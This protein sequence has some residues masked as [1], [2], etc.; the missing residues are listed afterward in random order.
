MFR[1]VRAL[2][3]VLLVF[4]GWPVAADAIDS[5]LTL[6]VLAF[7]GE[8]AALQRWGATADY[9]SRSLEGYH[10]RLLPLTLEGMREAVA[11][12]RVDFVLTNTGNY[13]VLEDAFGISRLATLKATHGDMTYTQFGAVIFCRRDRADLDS[14]QDLA[15]RSMMAIRPLRARRRTRAKS[16]MM[17]ISGN[18]PSSQKRRAFTKS[19]WSP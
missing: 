5:E 2:P 13:V 18:P 19:A 3:L 7:R 4:C 16:S 10:F 15:G 6:G 12:D 17:G 11:A 9:L 1:L 14:L 8:Q